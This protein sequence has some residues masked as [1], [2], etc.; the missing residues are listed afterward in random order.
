[1]EKERYLTYFSAKQPRRVTVIRQILEGHLTTS[2]LFWGKAYGLLD[3]I[4]T[5]KFETKIETAVSELQKEGAL[6]AEEKGLVLTA[7]GIARCKAFQDN[8]FY[9]TMPAFF[10]KLTWQ[11]WSEMLRLLV[12]VSSELSYRNERYFVITNDLQVQQLFKAW[13]KK[14]GKQ[15]LLTETFA[16]LESFLAT[17]DP[18]KAQIF[19]EQLTGHKML[20]QTIP[21]LARKY[22]LEL[23]DIFYIWHDLSSCYANYLLKEEFKS[24]ELVLPFMQGQLLPQSSQT[25]Y[26]LLRQGATLEQIAIKRRLKLNTVKEHLLNIA[27]LT[28]SFPFEN[29][30]S[31]QVERDLHTFF[32]HLPVLDWNF[33]AVKKVYPQ[34]SFVEFRL[35]QIMRLENE[36]T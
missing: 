6:V 15:T 19:C 29:F 36:R 5:P 23:S 25:T 7:N 17:K 3:L 2:A 30:L 22:H 35:Y 11:K 10:A 20:G 8:H 21:Q 32:K 14:Y 31:A 27:L 33:Q 28:P 9:L 12:Q 34:L 1:M 13:L 24:A 16:S 26:D 4:N 18:L